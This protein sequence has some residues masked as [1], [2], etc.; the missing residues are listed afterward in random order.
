M[1]DENLR[2]KVKRL[3]EERGVDKYY[4]DR[5]LCDFHK[6]RESI[7]SQ[8]NP[9]ECAVLYSDFISKVTSQVSLI[10]KES[11]PIGLSWCIKLF[12]YSDTHA[13]LSMK[14]GDLFQSNNIHKV[15]YS[16][17]LQLIESYILRT[18]LLYIVEDRKGMSYRDE[19][20]QIAQNI[21]P[22]NPYTSFVGQFSKLEGEN[23]FPTND[24][25][26]TVLEKK[27][28]YGYGID[29]DW[30][31]RHILYRLEDYHQDNISTEEYYQV[32][33]IMP[34]TIKNTEWE[35]KFDCHTYNEWCNKLGNL[36][37]VPAFNL[38]SKLSN[39][40]YEDKK[41]IARQYMDIVKPIRLNESVW[42]KDEWT[43][44]V[45]EKRSRT[46]AQKVLEIWPDL[47]SFE[48]KTI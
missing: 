9:C 14:L 45:I 23:A 10:P 18:Y 17:M 22:N 8:S 34:Q 38:N 42:N 21:D 35:C 27:N 36:T 44:E 32:E 25:F 39:M 24:Y 41:K 1:G 13:I 33:H 19:F 3:F 7:H 31:C 30:W 26:S 48:D 5:F 12:G 47:K 6:Y 40:S 28:L 29:K 37:L 15:E 20:I 11:I 4:V 46:L 16:W 2:S 43:I